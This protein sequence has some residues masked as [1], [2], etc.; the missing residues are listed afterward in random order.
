[1]TK[2]H[3]IT[4]VLVSALVFT[5]IANAEWKSLTKDNKHAVVAK[6]GGLIMS[7]KNGI[8]YLVTTNGRYVI[9]G[10]YELL[11]TVNNKVLND[12]NDVRETKKTFNIARSALDLK[13]Q[14]LDFGFGDKEIL[15]AVN[16]ANH[17]DEIKKTINML[18]SD[19]RSKY[20]LRF[21]LDYRNNVEAHFNVQLYCDYKRV[22]KEGF[23]KK[24]SVICDMGAEKLA[25][26]SVV[27]ISYEF[28][29]SQ[30]Y[31][32]DDSGRVYEK[33]NNFSQIVSSYLAN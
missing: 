19:F 4:S 13:G 25:N 8:H 29:D 23:V 26:S 6:D 12:F 22:L 30:P 18:D 2:L 24:R 15:I 27:N 5:G 1:M 31:V 9:R 16:A 11:D 28:R 20:K 17:L 14:T 33:I 10:D 21:L 3:T 32:I 7:K